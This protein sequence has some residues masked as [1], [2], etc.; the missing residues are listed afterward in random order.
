MTTEEIVE[1]C[2]LFLLAG[3]DT[4]A[5]TLAISTWLL[6]KHPD[7]QQQLI[8]ELD[9]ICTTDEITYEQINELRLCDAVMKEALRL[10]PI[11]TL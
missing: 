1:Q 11:A 7:V 8:D 2:L 3:F 10:Y 9:D 5:N 6:T 4:T